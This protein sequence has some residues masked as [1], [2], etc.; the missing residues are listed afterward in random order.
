MK[1]YTRN[2]CF[3]KAD[4]RIGHI[5]PEA[6][7]QS[8]RKSLQEALSNYDAVWLHVS[9]EPQYED[10]CVIFEA[11]RLGLPIIFTAQAE[12]VP[13]YWNVLADEFETRLAIPR[14]VLEPDFEFVYA[15]IVKELEARR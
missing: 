6:E 14:C 8:F 1:I 7:E 11:D 5:T 9:R 12:K 13:Y 2:L 15:M 10:Y 4:S 3:A